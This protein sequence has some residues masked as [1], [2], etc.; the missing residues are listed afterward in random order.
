[1]YSPMATVV[2]QKHNT[3]HKC[4]VLM[5]AKCHPCCETLK[6]RAHPV[7]ES[8][9]QRAHPVKYISLPN[10]YNMLFWKVLLLY[11]LYCIALYYHSFTAL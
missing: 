11:T 4:T 1:M 3:L 9:K 2:H 6:Q 8:P 7:M 10:L 5:V